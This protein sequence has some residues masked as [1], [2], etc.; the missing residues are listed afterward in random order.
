MHIVY[1][2]FD[3]LGIEKPAA[4]AAAAPETVSPAARP[5]ID[6]VSKLETLAGLHPGLNWKVSIVDLLK[7]LGMETD[8]EFRKNL[9]I[10]L[11]CPASLMSDSASLNIWLH[12]AVL[13]K[14]AANGGNIP[15]SLL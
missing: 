4:P 6:V 2:I 1:D 11:D 10:E 15:T 14:I 9:A 12:K 8:L 13:Q 7:L 5:E 3:K